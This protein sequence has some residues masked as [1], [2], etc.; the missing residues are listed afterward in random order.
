MNPYTRLAAILAAL[1]PD[2]GSSLRIMAAVG[3]NSGRIQ[4]ETKPLTR[5]HE[6][7]SEAG[8]AGLISSLLEV[9]LTEYPTHNEL[10]QIASGIDVT[11][12]PIRGLMKV[13]LL[14]P[15]TDLD[16]VPDEIQDVLN[17]GLTIVRSLLGDVTYTEFVRELRRVQ[18]DV[19][20]LSMHGSLQGWQFHGGMV[21]GP[22][23]TA[24]VRG[25]FQYVYLNT[26]ESFRVAQM[27]QNEGEVDVIC[28]IATIPDIDAYRTGSLLAAALAQTGDF[29]AAY[30]RSKPGNN[31]DYLY[32][33][34]SKKK[35]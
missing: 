8:K 14:A 30:D 27:L 26:C 34:G 22:A 18:A 35:N 2:E 7:V 13:F 31:V 1:Y 23:M 21:D 12:T 11:V 5:W 16:F 4:A 9:A 28:T 19:L 10:H 24:L 6:I 29:R 17:S 20:W 3:L 33:S 15:K 25:R 32:L